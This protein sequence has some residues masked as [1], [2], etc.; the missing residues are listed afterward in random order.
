MKVTGFSF[1]KNAVIYDYPIAEAVSSVL[2][3]CDE[4]VI[5]NGDSEDSTIDLISNI[6]SQK[7]K[8]FD[9]IWNKSL[10]SGGLVLSDETNKALNQ[11]SEDTD[12]AFYIQGDEVIHE[13]Y[14]DV[15]YSEMLKYK[16]NAQVDGLLFNYLHFYGSYDY[17]G[18]STRWYRREIRIIK[19]KKSIYSFGD[20]QGFRKGNNEKLNVVLIPAYVYHYGWVKNPE[21]MQDK[22]M[23]FH[24]LWHD[25]NWINNNIVSGSSFDYSGIDSLEFFEGTHPQVMQKRINEKNWQFSHDISKKNVSFKERIRTGIES[26]TGWRIGEYRNYK[27]IR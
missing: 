25:E 9:T 19:T 6:D 1:I 17:V 18:A 16:D 8:I 10:K 3:V 22:Q 23:Q 11:I 15:I 2:P 27:L 14:L 24:K 13:K 12:W 21:I 7:I 4:F 5:A 20:A 26:L